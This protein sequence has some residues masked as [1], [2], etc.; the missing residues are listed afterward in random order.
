[1]E[2]FAATRVPAVLMRYSGEDPKEEQQEALRHVKT[3]WGKVRANLMP[4]KGQEEEGSRAG[5]DRG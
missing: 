4:A 1:M 3:L 5:E 2:N